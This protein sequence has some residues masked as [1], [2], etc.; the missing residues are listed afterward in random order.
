MSSPEEKRAARLKYHKQYYIDHKDRL[1][2]Y[3]SEKFDCPICNGKFTTC[4]LLGH[5]RTKKHREA[6]DTHAKLTN[7]DPAVVAAVFMRVLK[8]P[9]ADIKT[10][11]QSIYKV[12]EPEVPPCEASTIDRESSTE[13]NDPELKKRVRGR[14]R[15]DRP[16]QRLEGHSKG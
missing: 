10:V 4:H 6:L 5:T 2:A 16:I 15:L 11:L 9:E 13:S 7:A 3:R 1:T 14:P 8:Q 12:N